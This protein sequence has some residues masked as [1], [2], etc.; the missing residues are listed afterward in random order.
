[1]RSS[2][3]LFPPTASPLETYLST[4][5]LEEAHSLALNSANVARR[6]MLRVIGR[7][8]EVTR[9]AFTLFNFK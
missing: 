8:D 9:L 6:M 4:C 1:M 3:A 5:V 7:V 2:Q